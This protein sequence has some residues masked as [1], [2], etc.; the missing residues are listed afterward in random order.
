MIDAEAAGWPIA[1][2]LAAV[3]RATPDIEH[4]VV[5]AG[6]GRSSSIL[7]RTNVRVDAH[8]IGVRHSARSTGRAIAR[9]IDALLGDDANADAGSTHT[10]PTVLQGWPGLG[11]ALEHASLWRRLPIAPA[12]H[13]TPRSMPIE[14]NDEVA[15][16]EEHDDARESTSSHADRAIRHRVR[17][18]FIHEDPSALVVLHLGRSGG[19]IDAQLAAYHGGIMSFAGL[20]TVTALPSGMSQQIDRARRFVQHHDDAWR[21]LHV[22]AHPTTLID[23][24][25]LVLIM[26]SPSPNDSRP[27]GGELGH[28]ALRRVPVIAERIAA[29]RRDPLEDHPLAAGVTFVDPDDRMNVAAAALELAEHRRAHDAALRDRLEAAE[30]AAS[31]QPPDRWAERLRSAWRETLASAGSVGV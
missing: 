21:V 5:A 14:Q 4:R 7:R 23:A 2:A 1:A 18:A 26:R 30:R 10:T 29:G 3:I 15:A 31:S 16:V 13:L 20:R 6:T 17:D 19:L 28:V 22:D 9:A 12:L 25:D 11:G 27:L 24:A 8:A